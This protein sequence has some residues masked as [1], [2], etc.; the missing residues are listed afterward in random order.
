MIKLA[1]LTSMHRVK[2]G[3]IFCPQYLSH[4]LRDIIFLQFQSIL[5]SPLT[6]FAFSFNS[7]TDIEENSRQ[8]FNKMDSLFP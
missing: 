3:S 1:K 8:Q 5:F 6:P 4:K 2:E 7:T